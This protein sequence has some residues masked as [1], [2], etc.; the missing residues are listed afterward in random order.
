MNQ[1]YKECPGNLTISL[2]EGSSMQNLLE[3]LAADLEDKI[4]LGKR[5]T[6]I[7]TNNDGFEAAVSINLRRG[8]R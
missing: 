7:R 3:S 2:R 1:E 5:V 8:G 4:W 6:K